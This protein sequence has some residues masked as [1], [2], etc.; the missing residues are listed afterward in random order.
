MPEEKALSRLQ[1][2]EDDSIPTD[3]ESEEDQEIPD[4]PSHDDRACEMEMNISGKKSL[5]KFRC[6][7]EDAILGNY[8]FGAKG[9]S[10][11]KGNLNDNK[12][13]TLWGV[14]LLPSKGHEGTNII[15][16]KFLKAKDYKVSDAFAML[17]KMMK[18]RRDF[19][20]DGI[21]D[22]KLCPELENVWRING[23]D[24]EGRP[25]CYLSFRDFPD[26]EMKKK[27]LRADGKLEE[28]LRWRIQCIEKGIQML[29]FNP[30]GTNCI[31]Q[32]S[33]FKNAPRQSIKE[34]RWFCKKM[35]NLLHDYYPGIMYKDLF[36]NV[37]LW[38]F[39]MNALN[40]RQITARSKN[41]FIFIKSAKVTK[42]L[43]KYINPENLLAEYGGLKREN[44]LEFSTL[45]KVL[46]LNV[47]ANTVE[48]IQIPVNEAERT[49]TWDVIIVGSE[50]TYKEEFV[51]IDD[52]SYK[53]LLQ[54]EKKMG[55]GV[56]N[57]FY[58]REPGNI[59]ITIGNGTF[60]KKKQQQQQD[61]QCQIQRLNPQ[62]PRDQIQAEAGVTEFWNHNDKQFQCAGVAMLR[63]TIQPRGFLLPSYTNAPLLAYVVRGRGF[64]G[65]MIPGC[66]ETFQS[67]Q[68]QLDRRL[69]FQDR[70][71]KIGHLREGDIIAFSA[72]TA[73]W[74]YNEGDQELVLVVLQDTTN[75]INQ[76]DTNPR[77]FFIAG[78]PR[79][80]QQQQ[81][82]QGQQGQQGE[83]QWQYWGNIF[84]GFEVETLSDAFN[85]NQETAKKLQCEDDQRGH[86]IKVDEGL[87]VLRPPITQGQQQEQEYGGQQGYNGLEETIC[88]ARVRLNIDNPSRADFYNPQAGRFTTI[89]SYK[90]PILGFLKLSA[91]RGVL[92]RN[93]IFTPH[94]KVN[95][96]GVIYVTNG[97]ARVQIVDHRGENV[98][99]EQL[100]EGQIV[101]VPMNYAIVKQAGNQGFE[102]VGF[103]TNDKAMINTIVGRTS[104]F[105]GL[106]TSVIANALQ[107]S[108]DQAQQLKFNRQE[109]L[110][111][112]GK[113]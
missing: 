16:M 104:T 87:K 43:L 95:S 27:L 55:K 110:I 13:I 61:G 40:L 18:W 73:H 64:F 83:Q 78:N 26:K 67:S 5:L 80:Y 56:R 7:V 42:T 20:V 107:I 31:V 111:F 12:D 8:I 11:I 48:H 103:N 77:R 2:K 1:A 49:V 88:T 35:I 94:W 57:S 3:F 69:R 93:A 84:R 51:P 34:L 4:Q 47:R 81:Q 75:N 50:V 54:K 6:K 60:K 63:H 92:R 71:Q 41:K 108:E 19:K 24:K 76:L 112:R 85:V 37:P 109:T 101:V 102:W 82:Q 86:I 52:C 9:N 23:V 72:G 70:H 66:P 90:L 17:S 59:V 62:E 30:G 100:R 22:E 91:E 32:I 36:I 79:G 46:E 25:L 97:E 58:I 53:V 96:H 89:N 21:L 10:R 65:L 39:A 113:D 33:D 98:L 106:P 74:V 44:D 14:P 29:N 68:T 99:D 28:F 105:R 45:D 15:L 38:F